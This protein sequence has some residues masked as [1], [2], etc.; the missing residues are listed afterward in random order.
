MTGLRFLGLLIGIVGILLTFLAYRGPKWQ[1]GNFVLFSLISLSLIIVSV[2]PDSLNKITDILSLQ[3]AE[4]GRLLALLI[5]TSIFL[6]F[7]NFYMR[8]KIERLS[9]QFDR[10]IRKIGKDTIELSHN[11]KEKIKPVMLLIPAYNEAENLA[12]LLPRIPRSIGNIEVGVLV[13]D[14]GS[15]DATPEIARQLGCLV[16]SNPI[17]RGQGGA[18]RLGYDILIENDVLIGITMDADNQ[19]RPEDIEVLI[20]PILENRSDLVIGSRVL[21]H[22]ERDSHIRSAGVN[23]LSKIVSLVLGQVI[24]DC[25]SGFKAFNVKRLHDITLTEDQFQAAEVLIES[26]KKGLRISE[27]PITIKKRSYGK[28]KKGKDFTYAFNFTKTIIKTWWR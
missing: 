16:V 21:G 13:I 25:S 3:Q 2:N 17:N 5:T 9:L 20:A 11:F 8:M 6:L 18:S 10:L 4:Y 1:K 19:H 7:Y 14:D 24:T 23:V 15:I 27:V 12:E 22:H 28:S 26:R